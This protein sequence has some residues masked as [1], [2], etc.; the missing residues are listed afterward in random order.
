[1]NALKR[2]SC[3]SAQALRIS[4]LKKWKELAGAG[5]MGG[6]AMRAFLLKII[7]NLEKV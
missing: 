6:V 4:I 5:C 1:M 2:A 7:G 3:D